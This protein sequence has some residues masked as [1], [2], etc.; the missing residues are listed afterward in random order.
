MPAIGSNLKFGNP[1]FTWKQVLLKWFTGRSGPGRIH[2]NARRA[3]AADDGTT[4][5]RAI[6]LL[7]KSGAPSSNTAADAPS[8]VGD[9]CWDFTNSDLYLCTA[10]VSTTSHTWTS[11]LAR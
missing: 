2:P 9:L 7:H 11:I 8:G 6:N 1:K 10:Y 5:P 3:G 4:A